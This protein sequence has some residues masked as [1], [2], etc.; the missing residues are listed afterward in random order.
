MNVLAHRDLAAPLASLPLGG[1]ARA[2][3]ELSRAGFPVPP[4]F[5]VLSDAGDADVAGALDAT[6]SEQ[7]NNARFAVRSSALDEDS[8]AHSFAGQLESFLFV[9]RAEVIRRVADVR[10]SGRSERVLAY[11]R[12]RG[13]ADADRPPAV[14]VQRMID[15]VAAGVAFSADPVSGRRGV[16][17]VS[18]V[19]GL[20]SALVNGEADADTFRVSRAGEILTREIAHKARAH[21]AREN[22]DGTET[23]INAESQADRP[24]LD[25][26]QILAV[27]DLARRCAQQFDGRPQ[28]IE[29]AIDDA[30][31]LWLLQ[32]RPITSLGTLA[33]PN[34]LPQLWDNSN[35]AESYNG[36]TTPLTFSFARRAY[37]EVYRQF[38]LLLRVPPE[39]VAAH[40]D[41]FRRMLGLL[42]GRIYYNLLS[43]YR[44]LA[45]LPGYQLNRPFMEGMMGVKESLP[46]KLAAEVEKGNASA[47]QMSRWRDGCDLTNSVLGL[48][49]N[50]FTLPRQIAAFYKRLN[51]A[52]DETQRPP[53]H[54]LRADELL[55]HY[56]QL[57][58]ALLTRWDA[59]LVNDF[60]AMIFHGALRKLCARW[61]GDEALSNDLVGGEGGIISAEPARRVRELSALAAPHPAL[62]AALCE[63]DAAAIRHAARQHAEFAAAWDAH[64]ARF[65]DRC[66]EELKLE[67]ATL[68]DNPLPLARAVGRLARQPQ[69]TGVT[70]AAAPSVSRNLRD[71]AEKKARA[72][73][74]GNPLRRAVFG[75][76]LRQARARVGARENLRFERTR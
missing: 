4:W 16:A 5:A 73:L 18:A 45:L 31:K 65:G 42:D 22:G 39:R 35:I 62:V 57:E 20:G 13:L 12:E 70:N 72:S 40:A 52:L 29:W 64:L 56:R 32:S 37:E 26:A 14:L 17:V 8:G 60:F 61:C 74:A 30:G 43:W 50:Y 66:L 1:K 6:F 75:W 19:W 51:A 47:T 71:D 28:D 59:P 63:G 49:W 3:A 58:R 25:D 54:E 23:R 24:A 7:E 2:L 48:V 46:P 10:A 9:P 34:G 33:D 41:T 69:T 36:V 11:R 44:V 21:R 38:C 67:T 55:A 76:V 27:A 15:A 68:T 53:L